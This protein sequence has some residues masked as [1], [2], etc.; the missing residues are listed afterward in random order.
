MSKFTWI[1]WYVLWI[2]ISLVCLGLGVA[3]YFQERTFLAH[4][5]LDT[6]TIT[7]YELHVRNDGKS[8]F[9]PRI[10][11]TDKAGEPVAVQGSDCPSRPDKS[12]IGQTVQVYYD[13]NNPDAYEEKTATTGFDGLIFG[14]IGA[15]FF[16]LFWFV[17]M[18]VA[19]VRKLLPVIR[20]SPQPYATAASASGLNDTMR[21]DA[22]RYHANQ[23][24]REKA[25]GKHH[26]HPPAAAPA[27]GPANAASVAAEEARLAQLKQQADELQ[28]QIDELRRQ[29]GQ[30]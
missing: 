25:A 4:A 28:R 10:E 12:K 29:Q 11:F 24:A 5:E 20:G 13:P 15:T 17:P 1:F 16:G 27:P 9:C 21:Q 30:G 3:N 19:L 14:L 26:P 2:A 7:Q 22:E 23:L 8:E 6:G 18:V